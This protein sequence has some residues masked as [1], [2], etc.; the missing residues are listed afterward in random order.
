MHRNTQTQYKQI[1]SC[2]QMFV[3]CGNR[4]RNLLRNRQVFGPLRQSVVELDLNNSYSKGI[5]ANIELQVY[6]V[7]CC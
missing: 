7:T 5:N 2:T 3:L 1:W 4:T 6:S